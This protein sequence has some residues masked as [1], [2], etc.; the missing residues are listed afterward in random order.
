MT[1]GEAALSC[2]RHRDVVSGHALEC[3]AQCPVRWLV[4][5]QLQPAQLDPDE[6]PLVR[7]SFMHDVL[8]RVVAG[9]GG[10]VTVASLPEAERRLDELTAFPPAA[11]APGSPPA[12]RRA[13]LHGIEAD[14]RRYLRHEALDGCEWVPDAL[15]LRFG[16]EPDPAAERDAVPAVE[17]S[18][19]GESVLLRGVIDRVDVEPGGR[20]AI[21]RDYK[22][23]ANRPERAAAKWTEGA[24][25]QVALYMI[26]VRRLLELDPIAGL[27]QPL[28]G[29][30]MRAR[31]AFEA[32]VDVGRSVYATD[33]LEADALAPPARRDRA[34]RGRAGGHAA[35]RR[36]DPVAGVVLAR[37]LPAPGN[38]LGG[39]VRFTDEQTAA[40]ERR[41]GELLLDAGAG[42]GKTSVLVERFARARARRR[43]RRRADP[44]DHVH[45]EGRG[46]APRADPRAPAR[47]R[48]AAAAR[49][50][51]GALDLDDPRVLRA[52]AARP[53][54]PTPVSI[55]RF[56]SSTSARPRSCRRRRSTT[57][58][59]RRPRPAGA[60]I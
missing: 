23:G 33:A 2:V 5:P 29:R 19:G 55:R 44:G 46:R 32:G 4:E 39:P 43:R 7:G 36:A 50:T 52:R 18:S 27:Y 22:S 34:H 25:F 21:V 56:A 47:A 38:L 35:A 1:L 30:D 60:R 49:E 11:L 26:A 53:C 9:L 54:A 14:L 45:R 40:I 31:G 57:R 37:R 24:Q 13:L 3:F 15:E 58:S 59:R 12:V 6:L 8:E 28:T 17:L 48:R 10:P 16:I 41:S 42:S 51:E 20:R